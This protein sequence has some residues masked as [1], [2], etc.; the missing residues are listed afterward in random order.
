[1]IYYRDVQ[2]NLK[3]A[4]LPVSREHFVHQTICNRCFLLQST[5]RKIKTWPAAQSKK[6]LITNYRKVGRYDLYTQWPGS[7]TPQLG[8]NVKSRASI[9]LW[10]SVCS[11]S[12][13]EDWGHWGWLYKRDRLWAGV[14]RCMDG[15]AKARIE[16]LGHRIKGRW[17]VVTMPP[18]KVEMGKESFHTDN[19]KGKLT[20]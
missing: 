19:R 17:R 12:Q 11:C 18:E 9:W 6:R 20:W 10:P 8:L 1:M 13:A 16:D 3:E 7:L 4:L 15:W 5:S 14:M 2:E